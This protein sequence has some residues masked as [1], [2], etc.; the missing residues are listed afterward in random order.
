MRKP[1]VDDPTWTC[2]GCGKERQGLHPP[3]VTTVRTFGVHHPTYRIF[4]S[5]E[6]LKSWYLK[7]GTNGQNT[8]NGANGRNELEVKK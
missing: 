6:C 2:D 1:I 4:C 7:N 3:G 8:A 5:E